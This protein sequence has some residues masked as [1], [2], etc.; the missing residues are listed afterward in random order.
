MVH[1]ARA[2]MINND[3]PFSF[4]IPRNVLEFLVGPEPSKA[5]AEK[6]KIIITSTVVSETKRMNLNVKL[7]LTPRTA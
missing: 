2:V 6:V 1:Y 7:L 3:V 5:V 4:L